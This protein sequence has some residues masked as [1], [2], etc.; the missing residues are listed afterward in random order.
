MTS[1]LHIL[2]SGIATLRPAY[3]GSNA[4]ASCGGTGWY[5]TERGDFGLYKVQV[6]GILDIGFSSHVSAMI[7]PRAAMAAASA[8]RSNAE[9]DDCGGR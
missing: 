4:R 2:C 3:G 6:M 9:A 8:V 7:S 1:S 5:G